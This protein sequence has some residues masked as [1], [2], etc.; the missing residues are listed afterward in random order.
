MK[1]ICVNYHYFRN[2]SPGNGIYPISQED[3]LKQVDLLS[4]DYEFVDQTTVA[5]KR[6]PKANKDYCMLTFDD[7]LKEQIHAFEVL[8]K[9]GI[10]CVCY[11]NT[12]SI[13]KGKAGDVHK[14]QYVRSIISDAEFLGMIDDEVNLNAYSFDESVLN[15]QYRYD[16]V[17]A[18]RLKYLLNFILPEN[19]KKKIVNKVFSRLVASE[20]NF[21]TQFYM[22]EADLCKLANEGALGTHSA[23]HR[24]LGTLNIEDAKSDIKHS[25]DYLKG[26]TGQNIISISYPYGGPTAVP[27]IETS[28][29]K[30]MGLDFGLTMFRGMN[31][32][33]IKEQF[34]LKR[35][36]TNDVIGGK[37]YV[38]EHFNV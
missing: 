21:C 17:Y 34:L 32:I 2:S 6:F 1:L 23:S 15:K 13:E 22:N 30:D 33:P 12:D 38:E 26:V 36:D 29:Y 35:Y 11:V 28:F 37:F 10:P 3:L 27:N 24:A 18:R 20:E 31:I 4:A 16:N 9:L 8:K 25:V 5:S 14:I 19:I 7:G